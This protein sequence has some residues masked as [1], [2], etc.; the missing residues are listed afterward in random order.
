MSIVELENKIVRVELDGLS[1]CRSDG[2]VLINDR[3]ENMIENRILNLRLELNGHHRRLSWE[4]TPRSI[5]EG[6]QSAIM[7]VNNS[8]TDG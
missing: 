4:A 2:V 1:V 7:Q 3:L 5:H 6:V 8:K